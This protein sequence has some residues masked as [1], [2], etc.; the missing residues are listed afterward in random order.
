MKKLRVLGYNYTLDLSK[1]LEDMVDN[2]GTCNLDKKIFTLANDVDKDAMV[3]TLLH[4][5]IE[6]VNYH[7][8]LGL[9]H[10]QI[11]GLEVGLNQA[12]SDNGG[13]LYNMLFLQEAWKDI[14]EATLR[15]NDCI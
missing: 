11:M 12:I 10:R 8:E 6:A 2:V 1:T 14:Y 4:E 5:I 9:E 15:G 3:S 7:L 13:S